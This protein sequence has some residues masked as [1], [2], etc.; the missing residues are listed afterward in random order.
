LVGLKENIILGQ[1]IPAGTGI[2]DYYKM[3][4]TS[5]NGNIFGREFKEKIEQDS[6]ENVQDKLC[7]DVMEDIQA[8]MAEAIG[9]KDKNI[10]EMAQIGE[11]EL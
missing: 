2:R 6:M 8:E 11:D 5:D 9:Q 3:S 4:V 7:Q 1:L 10:D